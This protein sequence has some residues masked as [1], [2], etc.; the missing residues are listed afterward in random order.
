MDNSLKIILKSSLVNG[1]SVVDRKIFFRILIRFLIL[2]LKLI[3]WPEIFKNGA[4]HCFHICYL[5]L[6]NRKNS[7][8][9]KNVF[10]LSSFHKNLNFINSVWSD[11]VSEL[12]FW[13]R[14]RPKFTDFLWI[15]IRN[16]ARINGNTLIYGIPSK[17][18]IIIPFYARHKSKNILTEHGTICP[19]V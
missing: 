19:R 15:W 9:E 6:Y 1:L 3:F 10:S 13:I 18:P 11:S 4:I 7:A 8:K 5:N 14:I 16:I 12:F 2:I 17:K